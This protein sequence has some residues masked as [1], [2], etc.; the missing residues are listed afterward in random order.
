MKGRKLDTL[1]AVRD[2]LGEYSGGSDVLARVKKEVTVHL[3]KR[4]LGL[5][6]LKSKEQV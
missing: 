1:P 2:F 3:V 4:L 6:E 5:A